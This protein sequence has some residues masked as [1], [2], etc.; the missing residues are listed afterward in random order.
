[1]L[2]WLYDDRRGENMPGYALK[3]WYYL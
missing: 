3:F 1:M 2:P